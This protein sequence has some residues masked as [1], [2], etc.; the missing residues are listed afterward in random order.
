MKRIHAIALLTIAFLSTTT[1]VLAQESSVK[2]DIP[3]DFTVGNQLLPAGEYTIS[4]AE[5]GVV[6]IQSADKR[7]LAE[8]TAFSSRHESDGESK[9][10]FNRYGDQYFLRRILCPSASNMNLDL[11]SWKSEKRARMNE[12]AL[13]HEEQILVAAR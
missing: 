11:P 12:A 9:L 3:F 7:L 6:E 4:S 5:S 2:A 13:P 1:A 8:T 10:V